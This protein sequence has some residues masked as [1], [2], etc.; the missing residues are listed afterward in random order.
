MKKNFYLL[1]V[2]L[3]LSGYV[4]GQKGTVTGIISDNS[5]PL[6]GASVVIKGTLTGSSSGPSGS[7]LIGSVPA[8]SQTIVVS[9]L[10]Y[11]NVEIPVSVQ[12]DNI[13]DMGT[14]TLEGST[15]LLKEVTIVGSYASSEAKAINIKK[16][17]NHIVDVIAT[18]GIGKLPDRNAAEAV[19]RVPGVSIERDQGEGRF[20][21]VRGLPSQWNSLTLNG[22]RIPTAEEETV[23]RATAF[24][25]FPSDMI[26]FVEVSK[27]ITPDME[28]DAMG[29]NV[30]F[31]TK[32]SP[33]KKTMMI[34][35]GGGYNVNAQKEAASANLIF[36]NKSKN[37]KFGYL[38]NGTFWYRNWA[39]DNYEP[40]RKSGGVYRLE[41]RDYTGTRKTL[42]F[43]GAAD[44][45]PNK[46]NKI[47]VKWIYGSLNDN[48]L[49]YKHRLRFDK[50]KVDD[51]AAG[52]RI[53]LQNIHNIL[54]TEFLGGEI[55]G[56]HTFDNGGNLDWNLAH[57]SNKFYYGDIPDGG[58]ASYFVVKFSQSGVPF[59]TDRLT[60][61][62]DGT[63]R[64]NFKPDGG[65]FDL[66]NLDEC[67]PTNGSFKMDP[68]LMK[69]AD[70]EFY[71]VEVTERDN[72]I[73]QL[74]F[75]KSISEK[76]SYKAGLKFRD[77]IREAKFVDEYYVLKDGEEPI[78]MADAGKIVDQPGGDKYMETLNSKFYNIY[79]GVLDVD[80]IDEFWK[81][82]KDKL[83]LDEGESA[84][85]ENGGAIGRNFDVKE[86][87]IAGYLMG[88]YRFNNQFSLLAGV[89]VT[90]TLSEI[91]GYS[92]DDD[93]LKKTSENNDYLAFLPMMHL[94]YAISDL[95]NIRFA[96]T[97][98]FARPDFGFLVPGGSFMSQDNTYSGG[99]PNLKPTYSWN[100]DLMY[101][102]FFDNIGF[103]TVGGFYKMVQDPIFKY[104]YFGNIL[105]YTDVNIDAPKNGEDAWLYGFE[106]ALN[107]KFTFL[108]GFLSGFGFN[109]NYTF[110]RSEMTI[111]LGDDQNYVTRIP[112]QA[113]DLFNVALYYEKEKISM[114]LALNYKG[115]YIMEHGD[116][117]DSNE[118]YGDYTS[119]DFGA[120]YM[121]SNNFSVYVEL[122]NLL[123]KPMEYYL[124]VEGRP[125]QVEY[126][127]I[128]GMAGV[129]FNVF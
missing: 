97:R 88:T 30:N 113:N 109:A 21:A 8:G 105:Q 103:F 107:K 126:Y 93:V 119:M 34:V 44:Y 5:G 46:N 81:K 115:E 82:Y 73:A 99:N 56:Q 79:N 120:T 117:D 104:T 52:G 92:L 77:K 94:K 33:E 76:F 47:Y 118:Y 68:S 102:A 128:R 129:K 20:V 87:H 18:D 114:R 62:E 7:F 85:L 15:A 19:Q 124:G 106:A 43:N 41:L 86:Q 4:V 49:H 9:Y 25:F 48:E 59:Y 101:E 78:Y 69:L 39:T 116:S 57:Y 90:Q 95:S 65:Y 66:D 71:I 64:L 58:D 63:Y 22:N 98:T 110:M 12:Q 70:V 67:M 125:L 75:E 108:P 3:F 31:V 37:G 50:I 60:P 100:V 84:T 27:A 42:G 122:M 29:G 51:P 1:T 14:I 13:T 28:G 74:N 96:I 23:S 36:G 127:G 111:P 16:M 45:T 2:L 112:R 53:E 91:K 40:R 32:T 89:R 72:I 24:D 83:V 123:N 6:P 17:S 11:A 10:G 55:G 121:I 26:Q 80:D 61:Y 35:L 38:L 54:I